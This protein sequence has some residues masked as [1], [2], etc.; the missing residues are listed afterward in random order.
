MLITALVLSAIPRAVGQADETYVIHFSGLSAEHEGAAGW[1]ADGSGPEP[2]AIGHLIPFPEF[3]NQYYYIA[4]R[5]YDGIDPEPGASGGHFTSDV[6]GFPLFMQALAEQGFDIGQLTMKYGLTTL[7]PDQEGVDWM[8]IA[9]YH[10]S[11][12]YDNPISFFLDGNLILQ[13]TCGFTDMYVRDSPL[14][15][16]K[17]ETGFLKP[18]S[19]WATDDVEALKLV[20]RAFLEDLAGEE[21]R[22]IFTDITGIAGIGV[23][24]NGRDGAFFSVNGY[25]E[26]G[27]PGLPYIGLAA[28]HQGMAGWNADGTGPEPAK[29]GHTDQLYY[30]ASRDYDLIDPDPNAAFG[31]LISGMKG[32]LNFKLQMEYLGYAPEQVVC[33]QGLASL[34]N[35]IFESDWGYE[36]G[37]TYWCNYYDNDY[38]LQLDG[39]DLIK[40]LIDTSH[41]LL[42]AFP[43][44]WWIEATYDQ[45]R[46]H[47]ALSS[48]DARI[49]AAAFLK[50]LEG[51][52]LN[53]DVQKLT[54]ATGSF[55]GNG[56]Y[57][58]AYYNVTEARFVAMY[59][60][61]CTFIQQDSL[62][63]GLEDHTTWTLEHSPYFL[64]NDLVITEGHTLFIEPGVH[65]GIRGPYNIDVQGRILAQGD[66]EQ[67]IMFTRSNP[68]VE[69]NSI[70]FDDPTDTRQSVFQY[71]TFEH[72]HSIKASPENSGGAVGVI[73][74]DSLLF[75]YCNF[76]HNLVDRPGEYPPSG[77]AVALWGSSPV[78]EYCTFFDNKAELGGAIIC[79]LESDP[80][81]RYSLFHG[82]NAVDD[83][84][85]I[86]LF[87][88]SYPVFENNTFSENHA[89]GNGGGIDI[90]ECNGDSVMLVNNILWNNGSMFIG[91]QLSVTSA[92]NVVSLKFN[93]I[94]GGLEGIGPNGTS[95]F[96]YAES[97]ID[98]DPEFCGGGFLQPFNLSTTSPCFQTGM[99][100][101]NIGA[102]DTGCIATNVQE[103]VRHENQ[104]IFYPNPV[105]DGYLTVEMKIHVK[106]FVNLSI[107]N[108]TGEKVAEPVKGYYDE[109]LQQ[110][111]MNVERLP[112]GIYVGRLTIENQIFTSRF[113]RIR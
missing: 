8:V 49:L 62:M 91:A 81:I 12:Y 112:A 17:S 7:G 39:E 1:N 32:F 9:D 4:S 85:A 5:D 28:D 61:G 20:G 40:G 87:E 37:S 53:N 90:Y 29:D 103:M 101:E 2:A 92:S 42:N 15:D 96:F 82:N 11:L 86:E 33:K 24:G 45:P 44:Y 78:I 98:D 65:I 79:Y 10:H 72:S 67:G 13:G 56:R 14:A 83:G 106:G 22:V 97:N 88:S 93:D 75:S 18:D 66:E 54:S 50:D 100:G 26:K 76:K 43:Y 95:H 35:D 19:A 25:I 57:D 102:L 110:V 55:E 74:H 16:W 94:E 77:G 69:W 108:L 59:Y 104:L 41:S 38:R 111:T 113:I 3:G 73:D 80:V 107:F 21:I 23:T 34:G 36:S 89:G 46:D 27:L 109:G 60:D 84:G 63:S 30:T 58:G 6:T 51:R 68:L 64:D 70:S 31:H 52:K 48:P 47:S 71:C 105:S 99:N